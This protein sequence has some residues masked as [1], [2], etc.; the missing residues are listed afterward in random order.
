MGSRGSHKILTSGSI[1]QQV[2][3]ISRDFGFLEYF[4][5]SCSGQIGAL[6]VVRR[7][8]A[9]T[10][11]RHSFDES[12]AR[13]EAAG[14]RQNILDVLAGSDQL[15]KRTSDSKQTDTAFHSLIPSTSCDGKTS[16]QLTPV[17]TRT[18][19]TG[20]LVANSNLMRAHSNPGSEC[21]ANSH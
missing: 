5:T 10:D 19:I 14:I 6:N 9:L 2:N 18:D 13:L 7:D 8:A 4:P 1:N 12:F 20:F 21:A 15:R 3:V 16:E 11:T 17:T